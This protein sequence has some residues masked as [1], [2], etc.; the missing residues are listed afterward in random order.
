MITRTG[1]GGTSCSIVGRPALT[2]QRAQ[3]LPNISN[4]LGDTEHSRLWLIIAHC[5][6]RCL[7]SQHS[8]KLCIVFKR[9]QN[10]F[11][12]VP[13]IEWFINHS[14]ML[15]IALKFKFW[16]QSINSQKAGSRQGRDTAD[17]VQQSI[18]INLYDYSTPLLSIWSTIHIGDGQNVQWIWW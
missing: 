15:I 10:Q 17:T 11:V 5:Q 2:S 18:S 14:H 4:P 9:R 3:T 12:L 6:L 7:S 1:S 13:F 8:G 16:K